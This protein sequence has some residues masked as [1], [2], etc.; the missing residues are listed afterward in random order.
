VKQNPVQEKNLIFGDFVPIKIPCLLFVKAG[1]GLCLKYVKNMLIEKVFCFLALFAAAME[2]FAL[3]AFF[4]TYGIPI[5]I[6][7]SACVV[8]ALIQAVILTRINAD[9]QG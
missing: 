1:Q 9:K 8:R 6:A 2:T 7:G 5:V 3:R 4:Q